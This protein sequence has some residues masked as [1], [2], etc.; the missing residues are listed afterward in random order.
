MFARSNPLAHRFVVCPHF[1]N[2][3]QMYQYTVFAK[4]ANKEIEL[5]T[6]FDD[7]DE[8]PMQ[9][10][11]ALIETNKNKFRSMRIEKRIIGML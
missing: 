3:E 9:K 1:E 5:K 6:F 7:I 10:A 8:K 2:G 11:K 4:V